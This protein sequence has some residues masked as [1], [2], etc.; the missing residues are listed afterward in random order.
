MVSLHM[1]LLLLQ[2]LHVFLPQDDATN[3][4]LVSGASLMPPV[5]V[6]WAVLPL[7]SQVS[8]LLLYYITFLWKCL[9]ALG[10]P[11]S[12]QLICLEVAFHCLSHL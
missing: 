1:V 12:V 2:S 8:L 11:A 5:R 7:H 4:C 3:S 10:A 6:P 9:L